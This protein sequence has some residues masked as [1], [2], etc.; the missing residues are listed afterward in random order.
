MNVA[1]DLVD[2]ARNFTAST[3]D[4]ERADRLR[5]DEPVPDGIRRIA[6]GRLQDARDDLDGVSS[7]RLG[8]TVHKT[9]KQI[10]RLRTSVAPRA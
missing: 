8:A 6:R 7:R 3:P 1:R 4:P 9:R 2:A 5:T 10:K